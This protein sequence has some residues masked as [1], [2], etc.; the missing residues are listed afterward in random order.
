MNYEEMVKVA[1]ETERSICQDV[2][3]GFKPFRRMDKA[4]EKLIHEVCILDCLA[5][6]WDWSFNEE[7]IPAAARAHYRIDQAM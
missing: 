3:K 7:A 4:M 1:R 5:H 6:G 2:A